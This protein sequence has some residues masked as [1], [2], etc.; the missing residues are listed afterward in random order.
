MIIQCTQKLQEVLKIKAAA[1]PIDTA[2]MM[3]WHG[4]IFT[5]NRRKCLLIT[6]NESLYSLCFFGVTQ[7]EL[8][9]LHEL[10]LNRLKQ[11][12]MRDDFTI[13]EISAMVKTMKMLDFAKSSDRRVLGSMNDMIHSVKYMAEYRETTDENFFT[14]YINQTPYKK[15]D[16]CYPKE[17]LKKLLKQ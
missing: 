10:I 17:L 12:M 13:A 6:H 11:E 5:I 14:H 2:P 9:R 3:C 15:G 4:N 16:Y 7:K 1:L 8:G